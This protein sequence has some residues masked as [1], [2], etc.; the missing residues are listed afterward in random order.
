MKS[1]IAVGIIALMMSSCATVIGGKVTAHQKT[2]PKVGEEQRQVRVVALVADIMIFLPLAIVDF[3]TGSIYTPANN[4]EKVK[5]K[6][7]KCQ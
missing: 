3:A 6:K 1:I 2:K 7:Q 5:L 4:P